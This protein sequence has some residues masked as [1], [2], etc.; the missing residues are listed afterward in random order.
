MKRSLSI[1][2]HCESML[3]EKCQPFR[4]AMTCGHVE[5]R[6]MRP[7]L[8]GMPYSETALVVAGAECTHC[9]PSKQS[10]HRPSSCFAC[11]GLAEEPSPI[12]AEVTR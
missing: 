3:T 10:F 1:S 8:A 7:A 11:A 5:R 2:E 9:A 4:V 6:M 12:T